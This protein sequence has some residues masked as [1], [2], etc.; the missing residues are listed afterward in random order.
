MNAGSW[1]DWR[2]E[3]PSGDP[4]AAPQKASQ[5]AESC[6]KTHL[7]SP[8]QKVLPRKS[9]VQQGQTPAPAFLF[10]PLGKKPTLNP[11]QTIKMFQ[12]LAQSSDPR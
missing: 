10:F 11:E 5:D 2:I 3:V 9:G 12:L 7:L 4:P 6:S 8:F 1:L